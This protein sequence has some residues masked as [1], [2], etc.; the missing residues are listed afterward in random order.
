AKERHVKQYRDNLC[1]AA[2]KY[3][4]LADELSKRAA[5]KP[6]SQE[7]EKLHW[8]AQINAA[9]C[10]YYGERVPKAQALYEQ[11]AER[12]K[13]RAEGLYALRGIANCYWATDKA[14][15]KALAVET[16]Q[17]IC[18]LL[19]KLSDSDLSIGPDSLDRRAWETWLDQVSKKTAEPM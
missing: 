16:V 8:Q 11:L 5:I 17:K 4:E 9:L 19:A 15:N 18:A 2:E 14:G 12:Y 7:D 10:Y 6:L 3:H 1:L 13:D